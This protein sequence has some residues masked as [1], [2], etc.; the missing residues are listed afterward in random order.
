MSKF[1]RET[2]QAVLDGDCGSA[3]ELE[4]SFYSDSDDE[5]VDVVNF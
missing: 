2:I 1:G 5:S 4:F 3:E